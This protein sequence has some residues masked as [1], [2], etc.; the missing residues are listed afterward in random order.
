MR[1]LIRIVLLAA[2]LVVLLVPLAAQASGPCPDDPVLSKECV[3]D[4][5]PFFVVINRSFE[6]LNRTGS[7]CQPI[8]LNF[9]ECTECC[10]ENGLATQS[11]SLVV[12]G[13]CEQAR[14]YL[15]TTVC[16]MLAERV[17]WLEWSNYTYVYEMCCDCSTSAAGTWMYR[18]RTLF[19]D[20]SCPIDDEQPECYEGLP[21]GT[22]IDLPA[23][24]IIGG[25]A[26]LG[27]GL[28]VAGLM[29]RRRTL[30]VA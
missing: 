5:P 14:N 8:I 4:A 16:P 18:V 29:V 7:G 11:N 30:R 17:N 24:L 9:P 20:G 25:L 22:G 19:E 21:P 10:P 12:D 27:A 1:S 6:D 26:V 13:P 2:I 23:P 15:E 3:P 28:L